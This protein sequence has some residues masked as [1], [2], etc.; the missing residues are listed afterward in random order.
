MEIYRRC[1]AFERFLSLYSSPDLTQHLRKTI[2]GLSFRA[3]YVNGSTTLITRAG[4]LGWIQARVAL[5]DPHAP[6]L[7]LLL[8]RLLDTCDQGRIAD[9]GGGGV[10][11]AVKSIKIL[12]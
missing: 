4:I 5:K 10:G 1:G 9:W 3:T 2:I 11:N 12:M 6:L 7:K 8:E